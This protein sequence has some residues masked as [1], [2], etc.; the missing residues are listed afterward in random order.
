MQPN[1]IAFFENYIANHPDSAYLP[2]LARIYLDNGEL[3]LVIDCCQKELAARPYSPYGH[4][5]WALAAL[6]KGD[7]SKAIAEL[8][9]TIKYAPTFLAAYYQ[10]LINGGQALDRATYQ[11]CLH[12]I[13][14]LN[15]LDQETLKK[16]ATQP[17]AT[18]EAAVP[19]A[20]IEEPLAEVT[21]AQPITIAPS[22]AA[23]TAREVTEQVE[24]TTP[25]PGALPEEEA[26]FGPIESELPKEKEPVS[27]ETEQPA[28][29]PI[30]GAPPSLTEL[31]QKF[32]TRSIDELQQEAAP[33]FPQPPVGRPPEPQPAVK[34]E[35][36]QPP[37]EP[38]F[39]ATEEP[40]PVTSGTPSEI[41]KLFE[42]MRTTPI[43]ELHK[44]NWI[45][46][47]I[48]PQ[49]AS[50]TA[51]GAPMQPETATPPVADLQPNPE[52]T[53]AAPAP[54]VTPAPTAATDKKSS[55]EAKGKRSSTHTSRSSKKTSGISSDGTNEITIKFPIPTWTLVEVLKKQGLYPQ[56]LEIVAMIESKSKKAEDL[57]KAQLIRAEIEKLMMEGEA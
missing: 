37:A 56:A 20:T 40:M 44:E 24:S 38:A 52:I 26:H 42:K 51:S 8:K 36:P 33:P 49:P 25:A 13:Q 41:S 29:A 3:E 30:G 12:Q 15:P 2:Q 35:Q 45:V 5:L 9:L 43:D 16:Y 18:A 1:E 17:L 10:L 48:E 27:F 11:L 23:T 47:P 6:K 50:P 31:F 53:S 19:P 28:S 46:P 14:R 34:A 55:S 32:K 4:Y 39:A 22:P 54:E 21:E 57:A 7:L